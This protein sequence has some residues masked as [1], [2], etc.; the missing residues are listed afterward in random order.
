MSDF[1]A[2]LTE[3][4]KRHSKEQESDTPDFILAGYLMSALSAY[5]SAV[6]ARDR[7]AGRKVGTRLTGVVGL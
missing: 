7:L 2:D 5:D 3:L 6:V 1:R 4:L